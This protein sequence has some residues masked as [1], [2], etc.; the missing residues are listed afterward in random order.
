LQEQVEQAV[1]AEPQGGP[2]AVVTALLLIMVC[3]MAIA[4]GCWTKTESSKH[5]HCTPQQST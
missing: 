2:S 5:R 4:D 1:E 3:F